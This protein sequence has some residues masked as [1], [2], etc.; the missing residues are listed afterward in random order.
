MKKYALAIFVKTPLVSAVKTRLAEG[1]GV[2]EATKFFTL[3]VSAIEATTRTLISMNP[4]ITPFW[5]VAEKEAL[6]HPLWTGLPR[7][8]QGEGGLGERLHRVYSKL[9]GEFDGV[10]IIGADSPQLSSSDLEAAFKVLS[11]AKGDAGSAIVFGPARDG[12]F[13]LVGSS[14]KLPREFWLSPR[15]GTN[16]AGKDLMNAA[17]KIREVILLPEE[18]DV[19]TVQDLQTLV[20]IFPE[21][22]EAASSHRALLDWLNSRSY[23]SQC[24]SMDTRILGDPLGSLKTSIQSD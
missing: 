15:Y 21:R 14:Q 24:S 19:D 5:A 9:I 10:V 17:R 12:G 3:S 16:N 6:T 2:E 18:I 23:L 20:S 1:I 8:S 11:G 4:Q 22:S 7:V 13:Y